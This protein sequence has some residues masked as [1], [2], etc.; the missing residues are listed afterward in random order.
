MVVGLSLALGLP[1]CAAPL[2]SGETP[3][4]SGGSQA[5]S[6]FHVAPGN[7]SASRAQATAPLAP[8]TPNPLAP[9]LGTAI[10]GINFDEDGTN[11]S[12]GIHIPPD[13]HGAVGPGHVVSVVNTSIEWHTK[14]GMQQ[15]SRRLGRAG[16]SIV[17]SFFE[18]L[19]PVNGTFDP[20]VIYD[21]LAGRFLVVT[22]ERTDN[23]NGSTT[24][25]AADTSRILLAVSDDSDPNGTWRYMSIDSKINMAGIDR[26]ADYPGFAVDEEAVYITNNMFGFGGGSFGGVR[27][28]I[29]P[30]GAGSGGVYDADGG[31]FT[32][33]DPYAG[34]GIATTTQPAHIYG[35]APGGATGTFLVSYSGLSGGGI[36]SVQVVRVDNPLTTP[37]FSQQFVNVGDIENTSAAHADAPQSGSAIAIETNDRR[38]LNAVWRNNSLWTTAQVVPGSGPD[39]GQVTAHWWQLNTTNVSAITVAQQGNVGG[40]DLAPGAFTFMP[41]I[42]VDASGNMGLGFAISAPSIFASSAYTGR[43]AGA[44]AGTTQPAAF[45]AS[46]LAP[47]VRTFTSGSTGRNRWGDYSGTSVDP[48][49]DST[50]WVFHEY[51]STQGTP[52]TFGGT[53]EDG[54]WGTRWGSFTVVNDNT[55]PTVSV[56]TPGPTLTDVMTFP[57]IGGNASDPG[58]PSTG[59]DRVELVLMRYSDNMFW[60][61]TTQDWQAA[62]AT[63]PTSYN[64]AIDPDW[65]NTGPLP[66]VGNPGGNKLIEGT[67][68]VYARA[69]DNRGNFAVDYHVVKINI[70]KPTVSISTPAATVTGATQFPTIS[71]DAADGGTQPSGIQKVEFTLLRYRDKKYWDGDSWESAVTFLPTTY[72]S[73]NNPDWTN[74]GALPGSDFEGTFLIG[75]RAYDNDGNLATASRLVKINNAAPMVSI[76]T[77]G[78]TVSGAST[79]PAISGN[80]SDSAS[81]IQKVDFS[82]RRVSD[83]KFW[84]GNSWETTAT[85]LPTTYAEASTPDW[86]SSGTLPGGAQLKEDSYQII[87]RA[88]DNAGN[89]ATAVRVVKVNY[90][91]PT[92]TIETPDTEVSG[93]SAFPPISGNASD[94]PNPVVTVASGIKKVE[95]SL[96][97]FS[98]KKFWDGSD[99]VATQKFLPTTYAEANTPDWTNSGPLPSNSK[100]SEGAYL[101][102]ARAFDNVNNLITTT[103]TV[104]VSDIPLNLPTAPESKELPSA[105]G[106]N[107]KDDPAPF[108]GGEPSQ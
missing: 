71:G 26:W 101:I 62:L 6:S 63:I 54:R 84:D 16:G 100:L 91:K 52:T 51:A 82:L 59:I 39:A 64:E 103:R 104:R 36:E 12:G 107:A 29:V 77:P 30:K 89:G 76:V 7:L 9:P 2:S 66:G 94:A 25:D 14:D 42:A 35:T 73:T 46:G 105:S 1:L 78:T 98:D 74:S 102:T 72:D 96:Y 45:L 88:Y 37:T 108:S 31:T 86:T 28:W 90:Q 99:W 55:A 83:K 79:F 106:L 27:L 23:N 81:G 13:P 95:F 19:S 53:T 47:Y 17:G 40:E 20:K 65:S 3:T 92:I 75:A 38:A 60:N 4:P 67:Y 44:D 43:L 8:P 50:F 69:Y 32:V 68:L 93:Q 80:A 18:P 33:H 41:S 61:S 15:Y 10:E 48:S 97:R 21:Q 85:F 11:N 57:T 5:E 56:T 70:Q 24:G 34:G 49:D 58:S 22:L 87:A